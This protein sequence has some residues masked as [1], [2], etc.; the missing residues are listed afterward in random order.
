MDS[1]LKKS[2]EAQAAVDTAKALK[3]MVPRI[4]AIESKLDQFVAIMAVPLAPATLKAMAPDPRIEAILAQL[5][6][7]EDLLNA[8][9]AGARKAVKR[10]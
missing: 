6:R 3:A 7:I 2:W 1:T 8:D 5:A 10:R 4:E 9:E